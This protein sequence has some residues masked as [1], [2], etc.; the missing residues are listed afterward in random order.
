LHNPAVT[1]L[2]TPVFGAD[3]AVKLDGRSGAITKTA[4]VGDQTAPMMIFIYG[5]SDFEAKRNSLSALMV[6]FD[7]W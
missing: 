4:I 1:K 6:S 5:A 2:Q 3:M 7:A